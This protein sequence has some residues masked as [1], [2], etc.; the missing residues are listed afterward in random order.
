MFIEG[1][2]DPILIFEVMVVAAAAGIIGSMFGIG[3]GLIVIP[4]L[5]LVLGLPMKEAI[6]ASL[7][8]IIAT[9]TSAA[10][11]FI[12]KGT[13]NMK[14][15]MALEPFTVAGSITG[16][17]IALYLNQNALSALFAAIMVYG[18]YHMA[19]GKKSDKIS[20]RKTYP[21]VSGSYVEDGKEI[22]YDV[23]NLPRGIAASFGAG[24]I[25]G[26]LGV[27]GGI[28]KVPV[29]NLWMNVPIKAATAT[30]NFMIGVTALA[31]A[32]VYYISGLIYP[33]L[34]ASVAI[35]A[36]LGT[37]IG[38]MLVRKAAGATMKKA[39]AVIMLAMAAAMV[40]NIL[41]FEV[42]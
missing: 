12:S 32:I 27:G 40:L 37:K 24:N 42:M 7:I 20:D 19:F 23:C 8:S 29:M 41:G 15:G 34:A 2:M 3:G 25:S 1:V 33:S 10:S 16:A 11:K 6:G 28:I 38:P 31:S 13:A 39:F 4:I 22:S 30:S 21:S 35:G 18:A 36:F 9:S 5:T 26:M 14:L 17:V